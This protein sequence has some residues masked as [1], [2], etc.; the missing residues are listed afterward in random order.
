MTGLIGVFFVLC[1]G[2]D[3]VCAADVVIDFGATIGPVNHRATG[4]VLEQSLGAR[5]LDAASV[6][7][8]SPTPSPKPGDANGDNRVNGV[9]YV[10]W[11]N[12]YG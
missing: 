10:V 5:H 2:K 1:I 4:Y 7:S 6:I 8:S 11:L 12:N 3:S 9:D